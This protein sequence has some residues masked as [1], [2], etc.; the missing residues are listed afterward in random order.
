MLILRRKKGEEIVIGNDIKIIMIEGGCG[1]VR[2]GIS[3][4]SEV[5]IH[6]LEIAQKIERLEKMAREIGTGE[7]AA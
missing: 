7:I 2:L 6:T 5:P 3:A 4:P 1:W